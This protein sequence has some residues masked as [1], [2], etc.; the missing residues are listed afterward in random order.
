L[1]G[2]KADE[3]AHTL[4]CGTWTHDYPITVSE[5]RALGLMVSTDVPAEVYELMQLYPQTSQRQPSVEYIPLPYRARPQGSRRSV[6]PGGEQE[7]REA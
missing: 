2:E 1:P 5:A 6:T 3:L 4:S 7:S